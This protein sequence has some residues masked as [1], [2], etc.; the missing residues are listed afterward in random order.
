MTLVEARNK[1]DSTRKLI[2]EGT[3]PVVAREEAWRADV[4][5]NSFEEI[6]RA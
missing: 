4:G 5:N 2:K 1:R 6:A 3:N